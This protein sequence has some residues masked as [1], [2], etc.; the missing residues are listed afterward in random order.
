MK[1]R[2]LAL[3]LALVMVF[4]CVPAAAEGRAPLSPSPSST[5][6]EALKI[7]TSKLTRRCWVRL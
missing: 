7:L 1:K 2:I 3:V 6:T 4:A 5:G